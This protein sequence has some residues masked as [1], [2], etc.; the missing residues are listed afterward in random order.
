MII[1]LVRPFQLHHNQ[2]LISQVTI[3]LFP[4]LHSWQNKNTS[5][6]HM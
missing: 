4:K 1:H 6:V 3:P 2:K 5:I